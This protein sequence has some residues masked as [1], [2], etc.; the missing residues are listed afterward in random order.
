M[1]AAFRRGLSLPLHDLSSG[2]RLYR[3]SAVNGYLYAAD[4][5][6]VLQ[7]ILVRAYAEARRRCGRHRSEPHRAR[8]A[9]VPRHADGDQAVTEASNPL[10]QSGAAFATE[11]R[12]PRPRASTATPMSTFR[13]AMGGP[14]TVC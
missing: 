2:F 4:D 7:E 11:T 12:T 5:F 1:D 9:T 8:S 13:A 6:D 14:P 3:R 10:R